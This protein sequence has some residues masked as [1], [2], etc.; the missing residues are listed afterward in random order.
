MLSKEHYELSSGA[1]VQKQDIE[2]YIY[3]SL[4]GVETN[5][6]GTETISADQNQNEG[7]LKLGTRKSRAFFLHVVHS[8]TAK[9]AKPVDL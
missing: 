9:K 8:G 7:V 2:Y 5:N 3:C 6:L 1:K 4:K